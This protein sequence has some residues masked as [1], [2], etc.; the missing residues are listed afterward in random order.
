M[1]RFRV[2]FVV[3]ALA[4]LAP[5]AV[6]IQRARHSAALER[7]M[8]HQAV[9]ERVFD[10]MER[11]LSRLLEGEEGRPFDQYTDTAQAPSWP[12]L[13]GRFQVDPDGTI[14]ALASA[15]V[16]EQSKDESGAI[17]RTLGAFWHAARGGA[18]NARLAA[19]GQVPGTTV[20]IDNGAALAAPAPREE[21]AQQAV[22]AYDALRS[23]NK[24]AVERQRKAENEAPLADRDAR[25]VAPS[26][27]DSSARPE[28][29]AGLAG[30]VDGESTPLVGR[31]L[32]GHQL[33][34]YRTVVRDTRGYRQGV[35][36]DVAQLGEWL[37]EQGLG[38]D[39]V[40]RYAAVSFATPFDTA[41]TVADD[42]A[43]V[44]QHRFAEPFDD[45][46]AR[47]A[48]RPLPG[49]DSV[50][51]VYALG[52]LLLA[53]GA[54]GLAALY[55]MV[56]VVV[57][58]A[59]RRSNFVAAVSHELKTPLTAIRMYG[60]MLRDG[61]VRSEGKRD[62]YY[63]HITVESERLSRLIN[64]VLEFA[65]LEK[66]TRDVV[67]VTGSLAPVLQEVAALARPHAEEQ[68]FEVCVDVDD[69]LPPVA[70]ERDALIQVLWNLLDNALKYARD[71]SPKRI[72]LCCR[73]DADDVHVA[74]RD[75]GPGVAHRH[76]GKI[77]EPFYRGE[78]ELT[79]RSKGTGIGLALVR[80]LVERMGA[81][82]IGRNLSDGG[83]EVDIVFR[84]ST[85]VPRNR[86][87]G[88]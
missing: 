49:V 25:A 5:L 2:L 71:A 33:M 8:R 48:L 80:G 77:F 38:S 18:V 15:G 23:L 72:V 76:L 22:S 88:W 87:E 65:R 30:G 63:R 27:A 26:A 13:I 59:E 73:R 47:L 75:H 58:F 31:I 57:S 62:E 1:R 28:A 14:H 81:R 78:N 64:N 9:A 34:L 61:M 37:R 7:Q 35:L 32:D 17:E 53:T 43:F 82:V 50:T 4:L 3:F 84:A 79:R 83:F 36:L 45:L 41:P 16:K 40:A 66:G 55:R 29:M 60:E 69:G 11:G 86:V 19:A 24:A 56:T 52:A 46:T 6:L 21:R 70:F 67:L 10:E 12:F 54:L 39:G 44:Y 68:G 85:A 42:D 74:V 20:G 51:Y